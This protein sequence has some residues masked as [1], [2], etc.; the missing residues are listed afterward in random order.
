M[1]KKKDFM[2]LENFSAYILY[3]ECKRNNQVFSLHPNVIV[4]QQPLNQKYLE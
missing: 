4:F 3:R 2:G 1:K